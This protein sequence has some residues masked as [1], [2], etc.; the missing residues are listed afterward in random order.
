MT[1]VDYK[2][3]LLKIAFDKQGK[4]L[5]KIIHFEKLK[6]VVK[7]GRKMYIFIDS[8]KFLQRHV[9]VPIASEKITKIDESGVWFD[10]PKNDFDAIRSEIKK[11]EDGENEAYFKSEPARYWFSAQSPRDTPKERRKK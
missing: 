6:P 2:K 5:G 1:Q 10:I 8:K 11:M 4:K 3:L 9:R 7:E